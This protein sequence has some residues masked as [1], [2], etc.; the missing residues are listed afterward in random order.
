MR[1]ESQGYT[2]LELVIGMTL[3]A[4]LM[5]ALVIGISVGSRAWQRGEARL[6]Q[7]HMNEERAS[8]VTRQVASLVPYRVVSPDP[9]LPGEWPI[10]EASPFRFRFISTQGTRYWD[11]AGMVLVEYAVVPEGPGTVALALHETPV[12]DDGVLLRRLIERVGRDPE[13]GSQVVVYRPSSVQ[14]GDLRLMTGLRAARFEYLD[15]SPRPGATAW[16]PKWEGTPQNP[17]PAAV[18]LQW[19]QA[20]QRGRT[21]AAGE[22]IFPLRAQVLPPERRLY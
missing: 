16:L 13:T 8:F 22:E 21:V 5:T 12:A 17:F 9:D 14:A 20:A 3:M 19:E 15:P 11:R 18:R 10:V 6:R 4:M 7:T 1:T 2:L